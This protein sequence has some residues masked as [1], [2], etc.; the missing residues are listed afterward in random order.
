MAA[1]FGGL[2]LALV[3]GFVA[4]VIGWGMG[5]STGSVGLYW[6][7]ATGTLFLLWLITSKTPD[8]RKGV[9]IGLCIW[10]L[11]AGLCNAGMTDGFKSLPRFAG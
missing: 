6:L 5:M 3:V 11:V 10:T 9:L 7:V 8:V 4:A 1:V 2:F